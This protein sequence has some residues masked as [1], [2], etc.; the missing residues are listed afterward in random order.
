MNQPL[1]HSARP[2]RQIPAQAYRDHVANVLSMA[3]QNAASAGKY[4]H[5]VGM[6]L[7]KAVKLAAEF[8]DL[9]KLANPNQEVLDSGSAKRRLPVNHVDAGVAHL[10]S[11][12]A[13]D[14]F[15]ASLVYAHHAYPPYF[16][17]PD[18]QDQRN[19]KEGYV[20]RDTS[21]CLSQRTTK[22]VTDE[23]LAAYL[24]L[25]RSV[26]RRQKDDSF[27]EGQRGNQLSGSMSSMLF[28]I[29]LGC[30]VDADHSDTARHYG[31]TLGREESK[32]DPAVR[33]DLLDCHIKALAQAKSDERSALR[34]QIYET[35]RNAPVEPS[36]FEC[37]S[38]VGS[39][40][41][42]SVMAHLLQA[43]REKN[44]RRVFVVLPFTNIINQSVSVYRQAL[45]R[46]DEDRESVVAAN[47][48]RVEFADAEMR[49]Y[50]TLWRAPVV[51]TTA[52]QFFETL[53]SNRPTA[54]RKLHRVPGSA[55]FIDEAH[56]ALPPHLWPLAWKW[57]VELAEQWSCH[58]V[59]G[60]GSLNRL[61]T[62]PDF[63]DSPVT[64][65]SLVQQRVS[66]RAIEKEKERIRYRI[67]GDIL[68][69]D[70]LTGWISNVDLHGPR[71]LILNTVQSAAAV[72]RQ[73]ATTA[74]R[75]NVEHLS[76][77]L[78]PLHRE[79]TFER[80][81]ARL[82]DK[83]DLN[84]TLV[85]TSCV[86]AGV[87]FSFRTGLRERCSL[88]SL[89]QIGGRV[90]RSAKFQFA[91]VW[92]FQLRYDALLRPHPAF[93]TSS[94]ILGE[95]FE[96]G[97]IAPEFCT[98]ALKQEIRRQGPKAIKDQLLVAERNL[99]FPCV[100]E[101]FRVI[102]T[103]TVTVVIPELRLRLER[104]ERVTKDELQSLSVQV[105]TNRVKTWGI[106]TIEYFGDL[107]V[108]TLP[109]DDFLGIM[110][111]VL[112]LVDAGESSYVV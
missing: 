111:G 41:T 24:K 38:P 27:V 19:N 99:Q 89:I 81:K 11:T 3:T 12:V 50:T 26:F 42:T 34:Q 1:A 40:K 101:K 33:L 59:L 30:L 104:G 109:Y 54:L 62:M 77:A 102:D 14:A 6:R 106:A 80:I 57:L 23:S 97:M 7:V 48:H 56:A 76:T 20:L 100:A 65:P 108:W 105:W 35:C 79:Q 73:I 71:L 61:W 64:L 68:G 103:E 10:L 13:N 45:V 51:V 21:A 95:F 16:G 75:E 91:D 112:P 72:A 58:I 5:N 85:A 74:G 15:A 9:G 88:A 43:A 39:G 52:V 67:R 17:L 49:Q 22:E 92:D 60:S 70:G 29:G 47:H 28:R 46:I 32:L 2:K 93:E 83:L 98:E 86:E 55:I 107:K 84:W 36:M 78:A 82:A 4:A 69:L 44:L 53:A 90:N 8:H 96:K 25:H 66:E 110:A 63:V 37:D 87:D 18:F 31:D 94:Q